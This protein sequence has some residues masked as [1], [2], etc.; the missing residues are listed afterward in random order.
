MWLIG[1][2]TRHPGLRLDS[3]AERFMKRRPPIAS[4]ARVSRTG[5]PAGC[6]E[7]EFS[8]ADD[9]DCGP[10]VST[11]MKMSSDIKWLS[12][13][14]DAFRGNNPHFSRVPTVFPYLLSHTVFSLLFIAFI[15]DISGAAANDGVFYSFLH[16]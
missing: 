2:A 9:F 3:A 11:P 4:R 7:V 1:L 5:R 8:V 16:Q 14:N 12:S 10:Q 15:A 6:Y 13:G